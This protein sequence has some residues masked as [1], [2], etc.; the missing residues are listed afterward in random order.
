MCADCIIVSL[1]EDFLQNEK[2][3]QRDELE[4]QW[5]EIEARDEKLKSQ[6]EER[7]GDELW[8]QQS[9]LQRE[10]RGLAL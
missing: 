6:R 7:R 4:A 10:H 1:D 3:R 2:A 9:D 8:Q 5:T